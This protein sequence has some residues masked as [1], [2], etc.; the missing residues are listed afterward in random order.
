MP[1]VHQK[2][3]ATILDS[4]PISTSQRHLSSLRRCLLRPSRILVGAVRSLPAT[5]L[6]FSLPYRRLPGC[7]RRPQVRSQ[8]TSAIQ[9]MLRFRTRIFLSRMWG[10]DRNAQRS[11]PSQAT[12]H[13]PCMSEEL[14]LSIDLGTGGPKIGLVSLD[15]D[16]LD[17]ELH[18]VTTTYTSDGGAIQD[19]EE[20]WT[21]IAHATRRLMER[22]DVN[23]E[24]VRAVADR[25]STRLNSSHLGI[26]YAV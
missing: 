11:Q 2:I 8:D 10:P 24:R 18:P 13:S 1:V 22:P 3:G 7:L 17:Y 23:K 16:V 15:G 25:K 21:L 20:W 14:C 12:T 6:C 26:S 4:F 9:P 5:S 19:P